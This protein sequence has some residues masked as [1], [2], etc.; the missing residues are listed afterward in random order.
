MPRKRIVILG[1]GIASLV[2]AFELTNA[3]DWKQRYHITLYQQGHRLGGKC[4]SSRLHRQYGSGY[5]E[6]IEEHG[7]HVFF[8]F[9][10]N[11]FGV[12]RRCYEEHEQLPRLAGEQKRLTFETA[13]LPHD[14]VM[15]GTDL[16]NTLHSWSLPFPRRDGEPGV[17]DSS[18]PTSLDGGTA[19]AGLVELLVA[20][21]L[22]VADVQVD[23]LG[24]LKPGDHELDR[25]LQSVAEDG[26]DEDLIVDTMRIMRAVTRVL[27]GSVNPADVVRAMRATQLVL[28]RLGRMKLLRRPIIRRPLAQ[29]LFFLRDVALVALA[30]LP[31]GEFRAHELRTSVDLALTLAAGMVK[32]DLLHADVDWHA[33][34]G[35]DYRS[36]LA[37]HGA[38]EETV[39]SAP[40]LTLAAAAFSDP[41]NAGA[42]AGTT[43]RLTL[44][45]LLT[46][47]HAVL[48]RLGAGMG[49]MAIAPLYR[50]LA[51]RGVEF[52]FFRRV[53]RL[54]PGRHGR[55]PVLSRID[56][57]VQ[58]R[59]KS[60]P[61]SYQPLLPFAGI[62]CW[63]EHPDYAQLEEGE[64]LSR[65]GE[66]LE[67]SW[68]RWDATRPLESLELGRDYD[69]AV[70]GISM[71][72]LKILAQELAA[73][74]DTRPPLARGDKGYAPRLSEMLYGVRTVE[75]MAVQLWFDR[76]FR[77][78]G[79]PAHRGIGIAYPQ[80]FDT[81]AEMDHLLRHE[82]WHVPQ[83]PASLV[84]LCS[85]MDEPTDYE[86][87]P[88]TDHEHPERQK[89]LVKRIARRWLNDHGSRIFQAARLPGGG[90]DW[91]LL[92]DPANRSGEARFDAQFHCATI[93][94]SD[95]YVLAAPGTTKH[96]LRPHESGFFNVVLAGDWTLN[97]VSAGCVESAVTSG[98]DAARA[99][100]GSSVQI[101][102]DWLTRV[103]PW[104]LCEPLLG[105]L[106][107]FSARESEPARVR[108]EPR[109][110]R[111][112]LREIQGGGEPAA[113]LALDSRPVPRDSGVQRL[114]LPAYQARSFD[115][116]PRPP[117]TCKDTRTDWFFFRARREALQDLCDEF[118]N[119]DASPT[120]YRP[121][122]PMVAFVAAQTGYIY[123]DRERLGYMPEKDFAFWVPVVATAKPGREAEHQ[124]SP[125]AWLQPVLW[126]DSCPAVVGGRDTF[127]L[128][129]VQ[130]ELRAPGA[131]SKQFS[132]D[133]VA[134]Q[135][136][137]VLNDK[138]EPMSRWQLERILE[139]RVDQELDLWDA[140]SSFD[141]LRD[142]L[143]GRLDVRG[144]A[145][146]E[147]DWL[148]SLY[149][150]LRE[151]NMPLVGLKQIPD[152]EQADRAC[153]KAVVE[154]PSR[155]I[156]LRS[157]RPWPGTHELVV[158]PFDSHP[159]VQRFGLESE[160]R[161]Q[162]GVPVRVASSFFAVTMQFDFTLDEGKVIC[163]LTKAHAEAAEA[164][165]AAE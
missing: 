126:V 103:K 10:E 164:R 118:L 35:E 80:P 12:M 138:G 5:V 44:R 131:E 42:G 150:Q 160:E 57:R 67:N 162:D 82:R 109:V 27:R 7:L 37:R 93:N 155:L 111:P 56:L 73:D 31:Q 17:A 122:A 75:T 120:H 15:L 51:Q 104:L 142:T 18:N 83:E 25:I 125:I 2:T 161:E 85:A 29:L 13:F 19:L 20:Q 77:L 158:Y 24:A 87:P 117:F 113:P 1:G 49:E 116:L 112:Q 62:M 23:G 11:A 146:D 79:A 102:D 141:G 21:W 145:G 128:N 133:T 54:V 68:N 84:Y 59:E 154:A 129:K 43:L 3:P 66:N 136:Q 147:L 99:L 36:W 89:L 140:L 156:E 50:V 47:K 152:I 34:D 97:S 132:V 39:R 159:I 46:Y 149:E 63:P 143:M 115:V 71:G 4:A 30:P 98:R 137:G 45:L 53:E 153:Y 38:R 123:P 127:G 95:R 119:F 124:A 8:G 65:S 130:A 94:P 165:A 70:L 90:F 74:A 163:D 121:L 108:V 55:E 9:Y 91:E 110:V 157:V 28:Q 86:P 72:G 14:L 88:F 105:R 16:G 78:L 40:L 32:E 100:V 106:P 52:R 81:W 61:G 151:Q 33:L 96:R 48:F 114:G 76:E 58:A 60:G 101:V 26:V 41:V 135:K 144:L 139:L 148:T 107:A 92:V 69:V 134:V 64:E 22:T 6:R